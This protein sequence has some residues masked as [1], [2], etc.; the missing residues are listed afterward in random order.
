LYAFQFDLGFNPAILSVISVTEGPF[1]PGGGASLFIP[2]SVDNVGG[3]LSFTADTLQGLTPGVTGSGTLAI[4][5]FR[6]LAAGTSAITL[7]NTSLLDSNLNLLDSTASNGS[8]S[9]VPEPSTLL[10]LGSA[11][12]FVFSRR[13]R[14][15]RHS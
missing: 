14:L 10:L 11:L 15:S 2:G 4:I 1:L 5:T 8:I 9:A 6:A 13:A 12:T 3:T 7:L